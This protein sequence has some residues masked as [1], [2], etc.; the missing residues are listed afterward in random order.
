MAICLSHMIHTTG[1]PRRGRLLL[2]LALLMP[3]ALEAK[4]L[5]FYRDGQSLS[6]RWQLP[7]NLAKEK[8]EILPLSF[9]LPDETAIRYFTA[10]RKEAVQ[11]ILYSRLLTAARQEWPDVL[12]RLQKQP[13]W[14]LSYSRVPAGEQEKLDNWLASQEQEQ[15]NALLKER[16]LMQSSDAMGRPGLKPDHV[17]II[18][19]SGAELGDV[20]EALLTAAGGEQSEPRLVVEWLL[21]F[22]QDIPY[23]ALQSDGG[24]RGTGY[25][26]PRQV[27]VQNRGD[28]DS[29]VALLAALIQ[30]LHPEIPQRLLFVPNHAL[31]A[32]AL[33]AQQGDEQLQIEGYNYLLLE[34]TGPA[35]LP[36]GQIADSSRFHIRSGNYVSE[37]LRQSENSN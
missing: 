9:S 25:L 23:N 18:E 27:L 36:L 7:D 11:Q 10:W 3:P 2:L 30:Y 35:E 29:K 5:S 4:Q 14:S 6:Y 8:G 16:Y 13:R 17:R 26:L 37:L 22:V 21:A 24:N 31:L 19:E 28:C 34:P 20:A 33:P 32:I 12:F 15:F 1:V